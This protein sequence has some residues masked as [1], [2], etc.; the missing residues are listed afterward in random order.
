MKTS[1]AFVAFF[2][3]AIAGLVLCGQP[4]NAQDT[5]VFTEYRGVKIGMA[6]ADVRTKFGDPKEKYDTEDDFEFSETETARVVY[7]EDKK[8][9]TI[10]IMF[11]GD[12]ASA[13]LAKKILGED[14]PARDDGSIYK[15]IQYPKQGFWVSYVKTTG[16]A[17]MVI[18][19]MQRM[20]SE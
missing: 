11:T 1:V 10:S 18:V 20:P 15:M 8:V 16:A 9:Q 19:T 7:G 14:V 17:P 4:V 12:L 5:P 13:P 2:A 6:M 3:T